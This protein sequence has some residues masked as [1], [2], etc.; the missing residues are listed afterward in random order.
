VLFC[1]VNTGELVKALFLAL[2]AEAASPLSFN[3][4]GKW[5]IEIIISYERPEINAA[6]AYTAI[7]IDGKTSFFRTR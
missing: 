7:P 4:H 1:K 3:Y 2:D 6:C 5:Y